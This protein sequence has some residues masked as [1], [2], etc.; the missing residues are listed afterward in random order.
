MNFPKSAALFARAAVQRSDSYTNLSAGLR[1]VTGDTCGMAD[2]VLVESDS[3][4]GML[5]P[6][7]RIATTHRMPRRLSERCGRSVAA[8]SGRASVCVVIEMV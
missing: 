4:A 7:A 1:A 8:K 2:D 6:I 3:N 5:T